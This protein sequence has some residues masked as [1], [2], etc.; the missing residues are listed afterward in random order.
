MCENSDREGNGMRIVS[1][2]GA[3][4]LAVILLTGPVQ[5]QT[6]EA[7]ALTGDIVSATAAAP[8]ETTTTV[9]FVP[10]DSTYIMTQA[11]VSPGG[12]SGSPTLS[13]SVLGDLIID[14]GCTEFT[15]GLAF[16][17]GELITFTGQ[18]MSP[19]P[20]PA[21]DSTVLITGV[22]VKSGA[23]ADEDD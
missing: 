22:L 19:F 14:V 2:L 11:C 3:A 13:G 1:G 20:V 4:L 12:P 21:S 8:I 7:G 5:G 15:P 17:S 6:I 16:Q 23:V 10:A 18:T 9:L